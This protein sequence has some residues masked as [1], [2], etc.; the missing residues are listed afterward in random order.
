MFAFTLIFSHSK[1]LSRGRRGC[2]RMV[3]GFT[4]T[5]VISAYYH[6]SCEL[7]S[8]KWRGVLDTTLHDKVSEI[9]TYHLSDNNKN[10]HMKLSADN[11]FLDPHQV[12]S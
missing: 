9:V 10:I 6:Q 7:E 2:G 1:Y 12:L 8:R 4:T 5:Y 11:E 3:I